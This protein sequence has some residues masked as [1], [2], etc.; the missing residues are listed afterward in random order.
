MWATAADLVI[1]GWD[2]AEMTSGSDDGQMSQSLAEM[3][4]E[5]GSLRAEN[6]RL[7]GLL[8]LD[9]RRTGPAT[10][11]WRPTLFPGEDE[12]A[13]ARTRVNQ[14]SPLEQKISL[15]RAMF[16]GREDVFALAWSNQRSGKSGWSPAVR[17][18][19][20]S[21]KGGRE[22]LPL[23]QEVVQRHLAALPTHPGRLVSSARLRF[24]WARMGA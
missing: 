11:A 15:Y 21:A 2:D 18:G 10:A 17:G 20:A 7:R 5:L 6:L 4:A 23:T 22:Y 12:A 14:D 24:R 16:A 3:A 9:E 13:Q 8:G 19:W 1:E